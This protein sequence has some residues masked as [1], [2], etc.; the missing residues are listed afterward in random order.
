MERKLRVKK[1]YCVLIGVYVCTKE[2]C[3]SKAV[4]DPCTL[5]SILNNFTL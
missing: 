5:K 1:Q 4:S 3:T 2:V